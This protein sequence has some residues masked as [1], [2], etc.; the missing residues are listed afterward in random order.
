M[1]VLLLGRS[2]AGKSTVAPEVGKVFG[3]EVL[4]VDDDA[5]R[6]NGGVWPDDEEVIDALFEGITPSVLTMDSV[7]LVTSWLS[8]EEIAAFYRRGF[9][10]VELHA[11]FGELVARKQRRGD[12]LDDG[13]FYK[14]Y[15]VYTSITDEA[16]SK[17]LFHLP[18]DTTGRSPAEVEQIVIERLSANSEA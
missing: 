13:R 12:S 4:E 15:S 6:L 7:L 17:N 18:L 1:N 2:G 8:V 14:N 11:A 9:H 5:T 10:I 16:A 3:L